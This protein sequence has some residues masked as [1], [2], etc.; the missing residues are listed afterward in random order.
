MGLAVIYLLFS[1]PEQEV[2]MVSGC[3][4]SVSLNMGHVGSKLDHQV[5]PKN[6]L[7][8]TLR[9]RFATLF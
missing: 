3:P 2:L 7:V 9:A 4:S 6:I 1:S 8:Y 5:K